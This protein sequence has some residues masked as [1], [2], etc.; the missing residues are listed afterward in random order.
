MAKS[1]NRFTSHALEVLLRQRHPSVSEVA[2]EIAKTALKEFELNSAEAWEQTEHAPHKDSSDVPIADSKRNELA[3]I[4]ELQI[5]C[6]ISQHACPIL[7]LREVKTRA[8]GPLSQ[9]AHA[10]AYLFLEGSDLTEADKAEFA[11]KVNNTVSDITMRLIEK[12]QLPLRGGLGD[13]FSHTN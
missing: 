1:S 4:I 11:H 6:L 13:A 10:G 8:W 5:M 2:G 3:Q 9:K 12:T 7:D